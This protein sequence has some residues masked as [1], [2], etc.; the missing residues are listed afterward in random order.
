MSCGL[1]V[2]RPRQL[3]GGRRRLRRGS[4]PGR[5]GDKRSGFMEMRNSHPLWNASFHSESNVQEESAREDAHRPTTIGPFHDSPHRPAH[6]PR[7]PVNGLGPDPKEN[8]VSL[9]RRAQKDVEKPKIQLDS[10]SHKLYYVN[11]KIA[12]SSLFMRV[13]AFSNPAKS[14]P[15]APLPHGKVCTETGQFFSLTR[16]R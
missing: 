7:R 12:F 4:G 15:K 2:P 9:L 13:P 5:D 6:P 10:A 3:R 11:Q 8:P 16:F 14:T 1:F